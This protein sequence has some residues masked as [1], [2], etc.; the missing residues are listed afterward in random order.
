[1]LTSPQ[2]VALRRLLKA[3]QDLG[4]AEYEFRNMPELI[5]NYQ[6]RYNQLRA[7]FE[8]TLTEPPQ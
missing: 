1:M 3:A 8:D 7:K 2:R 4:R 5:E 6:D